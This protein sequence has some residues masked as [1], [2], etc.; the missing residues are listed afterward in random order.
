ML[1][2]SARPDWSPSS[3][4]DYCC[5]EETAAAAAA[6]A[7][8]ITETEI[9]RRQCIQLLGRQISKYDRRVSNGSCRINRLIGSLLT[10]H[11]RSASACRPMRITVNSQLK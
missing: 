4:L 7:H 1:R 9:P 11:S 2:S 3:L 10:I 8:S 6:A 5:H